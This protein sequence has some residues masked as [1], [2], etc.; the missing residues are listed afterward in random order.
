VSMTEKH[1]E[2]TVHIYWHKIGKRFT[3]IRHYSSN[4]KQKVMN[5]H[6][7]ETRGI[8]YDPSRAPINHAKSESRTTSCR[9]LQKSGVYCSP[10]SRLGHNL[11]V[12]K[13]LAG[14]VVTAYTGDILPRLIGHVTLG[15]I[16][17]NDVLHR[18]QKLKFAL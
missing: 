1:S 14:F 7:L 9:Y 6:N 15:V 16:Q 8:R 5:E 11:G 4:Q 18:R 13:Y 10:L 2:H 3:Q 17:H 12:R